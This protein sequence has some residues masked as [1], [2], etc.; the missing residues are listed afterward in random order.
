MMVMV[1]LRLGLPS[2]R[3]LRRSAGAFGTRSVARW[4]RIA[5][6]LGAVMA[7][8]LRL[9]STTTIAVARSVF[10]PCFRTLRSALPGFGARAAVPVSARLLGARI[11]GAGVLRLRSTRLLA[12]ASGAQFIGSDF[13]VTI[14]VELPE[15][16]GGVRHLRGIDHTVVVGIERGEKSASGML[17]PTGAFGTRASLRARPAF[18]GSAIG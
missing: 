11:A 13:A 1:L 15:H 12:V 3:V 7:R 8:S 5:P 16:V 14:A 2:V 6:A 9:R 10:G 4:L 17:A 18:V